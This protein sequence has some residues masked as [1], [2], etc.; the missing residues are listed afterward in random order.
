V[1]EGRVIDTEDRLTALSTSAPDPQSGERA[2]TLRDGVRSARARMRELIASG[3]PAA[4]A[5]VDAVIVDLEAALAPPATPGASAA[6][7]PPATPPI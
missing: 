3:S 4:T 2:V 5:A 7:T 1:S 6:G